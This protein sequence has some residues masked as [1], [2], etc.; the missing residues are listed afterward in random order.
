MIAFTIV[1]TVFLACMANIGYHYI[2]EGK[3]RKLSPVY[4]ILSMV[5]SLI[6][7]ILMN[8][9]VKFTVSPMEILTIPYADG[10]IYGIVGNALVLGIALRKKL[11]RQPEDRK[12]KF[13]IMVCLCVVV[14]FL[15]EFFVLNFRH[16]ELLGG[17]YET[18]TYSL[19][20]VELENFVIAEDGSLTIEEN[21]EAFIE[22]KDIHKTL[23]NVYL[24]IEDMT[25]KEIE[26]RLQ[27]TDESN[28][29]YFDSPILLVVDD[30]EKSQYFKFSLTGQ[31][32]KIR[33]K[34]SGQPEYAFKL[35]AITFNTVRPMYFLY[36]R[37][38]AVFCLL[39]L[40]YCLRPG[41]S[42]YRITFS[43]DSR[44][45]KR[46]LAVLL[47]MQLALLFYFARTSVNIE[48]QDVDYYQ[49]LAERFLE[50]H[51]DMEEE[52]PAELETLE[53]RY[54]YLQRS[55]SY[56][57]D[58]TYY[59]G[60]YYFYYGAVPALLLYVPY[61]FIFGEGMP[62]YLA[63]FICIAGAAVS[64]MALLYTLV[65]RYV[66]KIPFVFFVLSYI[67][68]ANSAMLLD[69]LRRPRFYEV[70]EGSGL[71]FVITGV[72]LWLNSLPM[73]EKWQSIMKEQTLQVVPLCMGSLCMALA[74]GC[75]PTLLFDSLL[76][77]PIFGSYVSKH[78]FLPAQF[79]AETEKKKRKINPEFIR[80]F[81]LFCAPFVV[82]GIA[83]MLYNYARYESP[84]NFGIEYQLTNID[85]KE[86]KLTQFSRLFEEVWV[87][88][89][90][91]PSLRLKYPYIRPNYVGNVTYMGKVAIQ[92]Q[93]V[94]GA[95]YNFILLLLLVAPKMKVFTKDAL[96]KQERK[97]V[98]HFVWA[99]IGIG[100]L[101]LALVILKGGIV[102]RYMVNFM[103]MWLVAAIILFFVIYEYAKGSKLQF[104][105]KRYF[106]FCVATGLILNFCLT[107]VGE[108]NYLYLNHPDIYY[109]MEYFFS[110]WL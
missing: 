51:L 12:K 66:K 31:S 104:F 45:Q 72:C 90:N 78:L 7:G 43:A 71:F 80:Q 40:V 59:K 77:F 16:F 100:A 74:V 106:M 107:A 46:F 81:A 57:F 47:V 22:I 13:C 9:L 41:S 83:I 44:K 29:E 98:K 73:K 64:L 79:D 85:T 34:F 38:F 17:N 58:M 14:A 6:F 53:N 93:D 76:A 95:M 1:W 54:D 50:G 48:D 11:G 70:M 91:T 69:L 23:K 108:R 94:V 63:T 19:E 32:E 105:V 4:I 27:M 102:R 99:L 96:P 35:N 30:I 25:K 68:V 61:Q 52:P 67:L 87:Y 49:G 89:F 84:F 103:W 88:L 18:C 8:G 42:V 60:H 24:D 21:K 20:D 26:F 75:K 109:R 92:A 86:F 110:F 97:P 39:V 36:L 82:V 10:F 56:L 37:F 101:Q 3:I 15:I 5:G 65:K 28:S 55:E 2:S 62:T 33:L